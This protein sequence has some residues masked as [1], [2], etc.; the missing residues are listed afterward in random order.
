MNVW[1]AI[2]RRMRRYGDRI[3]F[4]RGKITYA[5][6]LSL[7]E[8]RQNASSK[9]LLVPVYGKTKQEQAIGILQTL[10][11]GNIP[12][13]MEESYGS[14][15]EEK[16]RKILSE[17]TDDLRTT[18]AVL[19][20]SGTTGEP[21]GVRLSHRGIVEN[22]RGIE[23]YF[24][25]ESGC[26]ILIVRPL[27][28]VGVFTGELLFA[29]YRGLEI[30]F[31]EEAFQPNRLAAYIEVSRAQVLGCTPTLM[32]HLSRY[33]KGGAL[34]VAAIGGER[35]T[36]GAA[37]ILREKYPNVNFYNVYGLTENSPRVCALPPES[38]FGKI[39]SV[40]RPIAHTKVK[41]LCGELLVKSRSVMLGYMGEREKTRE[42]LRGG[43]LHTGDLARIDEEGYVYILGRKDDMLIRS[44]MNIYPAEIE[45]AAVQIPGVSA[46][47]VYGE[48]DV[49]F[50]QKICM[51]AVSDLDA[52]ALRRALAGSLPAYLV[53]DKIL[54]VDALE[55]TPSGKVKRV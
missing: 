15:R 54:I 35:L 44:G 27:V 13:P 47:M 38:F 29:L 43:W 51:K 9:H 52:A 33:W 23:R 5:Q 16:I 41:L 55:L 19:F 3:A 49:R 39:G 20:T 12:V 18:A 11:C 28:H 37:K 1:K 8:N 45:S 14:V 21:K 26:R 48:E 30:D 10:A 7:V 36:D 40:G 34:Q 25:V 4:V 50:G 17:N 32:V 6:L 22:L 31:Y 24:K 53:P 42:K 2:G 46:C